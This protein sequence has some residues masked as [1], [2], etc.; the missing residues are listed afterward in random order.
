MNVVAAEFGP[1]REELD[2]ISQE[3]GDVVARL[4]AHLRP[5]EVRLD[6]TQ[7]EVM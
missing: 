4:K 6:G 7:V 5:M 3:T 1:R 2:K